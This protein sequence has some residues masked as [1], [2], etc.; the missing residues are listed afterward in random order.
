ML[1]VFYGEQAAKRDLLANIEAIPPMH[2]SPPA[3]MLN[4]P[5]MLLSKRSPRRSQI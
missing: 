3:A 1:K 4:V 5:D 2:G